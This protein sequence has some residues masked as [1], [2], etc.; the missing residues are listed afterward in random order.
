MSPPARAGDRRW[1][2]HRGAI[3]VAIGGV[4][5]LAIVVALVKVRAEAHHASGILPTIRRASLPGFGLAAGLEAVSYLLPGIALRRMDRRH[6]LGSALRIALAA[7]GVGPLLPGN[8]L[9]GSGIAYTEL[10]RVDTPRAP[11]AGWSTALVIGIPACS[12]A[13]LAGP[14]L[15]ASGL[16][17]PLPSGWR[18]VV[19]VAGASALGLTCLIAAGLVGVLPSRRAAQAI[20][21]LGGRRNALLLIGLGAGAWVCDAASLWATGAALHIDLPPASLPMAYLAGVMI[22][23]LP[24]LPGGL[25]AVEVTLPAV[26]AAGGGVYSQ[27]VVAVVAWRVLAFWLPSA[28]GAIALTSLHRRPAATAAVSP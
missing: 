28:A 23:S 16:A 25:G 2:A 10:R 21:A 1:P 20:A 19:L 26:F 8:P 13:A 14:A 17:A 27:A 9:T 15:I 6:D 11:A 4:V 24:V 3:R 12:M 5:G 18:T 7:M 22:M